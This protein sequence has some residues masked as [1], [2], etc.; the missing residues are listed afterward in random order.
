MKAELT[1]EE[2]LKGLCFLRDHYG[3]TSVDA[4]MQRPVRDAISLIQR[5]AE[6]I[7][8]LKAEVAGEREVRAA[9]LRRIEALES[10]SRTET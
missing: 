4:T 6:Q 8:A 5:Q 1:P 10:M 2:V 3:P 9:L 7:Q